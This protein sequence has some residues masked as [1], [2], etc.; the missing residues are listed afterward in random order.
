MK[1][2]SFSKR[3]L[4]ILLTLCIL[5]TASLT[6]SAEGDEPA[7]NPQ[8]Y[9]AFADASAGALY[10]HAT[11]GGDS[12]QA[13]QRWGS[14]YSGLNA[15]S[16][17]RY[18]FLP[19]TADDARVEIYNN[20]STPATIGS[21]TIAPY[22]SAFVPY[23]NGTAN[24]VSVNSRSYSFTVYK[25]DSEASVFV[26][27]TKNS[28][29][30]VNGKVQNTDL[31]S[32][33]IQNKENSVKGSDCAIAGGSAVLDTTLKKIK[34]RG[35][36]NWTETDKKPFNLQFNDS[37]TIGHTAGKKFSFVSNAKDSTLLRNTIMYN[38][39]NDA[40][41]P[42]APDQSFV[43]FFVNG[44]YRGSYIACEKID[45]GKSSVVSLKDNSDTKTSDFSFLVEVDVWNYKNDTYFVTDKGYHVVLKTP[46]L[47]DFEAG[48][49]DYTLRYNYIKQTYQKLEDALYGGTIADLEKICD[50][51]SLA[52][53]YLLQEFGKNCDG[54]YT[55]TYF[56][57]NA[58]EGKFYAA[59][60]WDC[61]SDLGAVDCT[62]DGCTTSTCN[63]QGW[64]TRTATYR[65]D[66]RITTVNPLGQA[67]N[68]KGTDSG[69]KTFEDRVKAIWSNSFVPKI[70]I[71][72][73]SAEADGGRLKSIDDYA[74]AITQASYNNYVM[75]DF[76]WYCSRYRSG[77]S[78]SYSRDYSGEL[79]YLKDWTKAR[80]DWMNSQYGSQN[81]SQAPSQPE[82]STTVY[83][84]NSLNWDNVYYYAW[85]S[86]N[87]PMNWPGELAEKVG[88][89]ANGADIYKASISSS[90]DKIIFNGGMEAAQTVNIDVAVSTLYSPTT[91]S[92]R[93]NNMRYPIYNVSASG[94]T[95]P[96]APTEATTQPPSD[97]TSPQTETT[98]PTTPE[99]VLRGD[100]NLDG[101]LNIKDATAVQK[102]AAKIITFSEKQKRAI[103][104]GADEEPTV[105]L[106]TRIQQY[107]AEIITEF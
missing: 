4:A 85:T 29:T 102:C 52:S 41:S 106:A 55:S 53:Q 51:D 37:V 77:L 14:G 76:M 6:A 46:D 57:Y 105:K 80:A 35:N 8:A 34:G 38:L 103:G 60:I 69:G 18:F 1:P 7:V 15:Q 20:Y 17:M 42:Y 59:P 28:Y 81:E 5:I 68:M 39:A 32:F 74:S 96:T 27:D 40:G 66:T 44:E 70:N 62:R 87:A 88:T 73:G 22:T 83:F 65:S 64:V 99:E 61:D 24:A 9:P 54:G 94:Y 82:S 79:N 98:L 30:D 50:L 101:K 31:Y 16:G 71:L 45:L 26:N 56:T 58:D 13:W 67:F 72:T 91:Q 3:L 95:E 90:L 86:G 104:I 25:S 107:L 78:G 23:K 12:A 43:D 33:L 48:T 75:W 2:T 49:E 10:A 11:L 100:A 84:K 93:Q 19:N 47:E 97:T 89:D 36:T 63:Y 21:V 92:G